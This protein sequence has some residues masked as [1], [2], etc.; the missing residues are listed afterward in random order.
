MRHQGMNVR[1]KSG[2]VHPNR[3]LSTRLIE[4]EAMAKKPKGKTKKVNSKKSN[5]KGKGATI[6]ELLLRKEGAIRETP[7]IL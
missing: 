3:W 7:R 4:E 6:I 1:D 2:A 5:G